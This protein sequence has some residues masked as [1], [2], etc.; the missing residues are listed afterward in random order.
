MMEEIYRVLRDDGQ[1]IVVSGHPKG[2]HSCDGWCVGGSLQQTS[3]S[4]EIRITLVLVGMCFYICI[5]LGGV[6]L[7]EEWSLVDR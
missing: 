6:H 5:R 2:I 1:Y 4:S 7:F 3:L